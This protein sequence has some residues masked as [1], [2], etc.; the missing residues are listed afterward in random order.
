MIR[1]NLLVA[2]G[3]KEIVGASVG[4]GTVQVDDY[5]VGTGTVTHASGSTFTINGEYITMTISL[6]TAVKPCH[7]TYFDTGANSATTVHEQDLA[8]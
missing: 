8:V 2:D 1:S 6:I 4:G 5:N 3:V 7:V